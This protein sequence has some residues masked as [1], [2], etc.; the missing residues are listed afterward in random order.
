[1]MEE[2]I[3]YVVRSEDKVCAN[4]LSTIFLSKINLNLVRL[5]FIRILYLIVRKQSKLHRYIVLQFSLFLVETY[6][7]VHNVPN[8]GANKAEHCIL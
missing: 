1:M 6:T 3:S 7:M 5:P 2:V 8:R 4:I